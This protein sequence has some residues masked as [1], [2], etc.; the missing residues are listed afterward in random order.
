MSTKIINLPIAKAIIVVIDVWKTKVKIKRGDDY[1]TINTPKDMSTAS[2]GDVYK[3]EKIDHMIQG[4][5]SKRLI[6]TK[7]Q[8]TDISILPLKNK[9]NVT[10]LKRKNG[11]L[12][13]KIDD[14]EYVILESKTLG[15]ENVNENESVEM[16][17][18]IQNGLTSS[19]HRYFEPVSESELFT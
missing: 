16:I 5:Q 12:K 6:A 19:I 7:I 14:I 18:E 4:R 17:G 8:T 9:K 3:I 1:F 2:V 15:I 13:I 10:I 11:L